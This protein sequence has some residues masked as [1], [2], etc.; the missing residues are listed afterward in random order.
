MGFPA[1]RPLAERRR[2]GA[3]SSRGAHNLAA[4]NHCI[5]LKILSIQ[6]THGMIFGVQAE[7]ILDFIDYWQLA[8]EH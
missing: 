4:A 2:R 1:P 6:Q 8:I 5:I 7:Q 3:A